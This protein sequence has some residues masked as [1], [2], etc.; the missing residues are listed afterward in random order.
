MGAVIVGGVMVVA[1]QNRNPKVPETVPASTTEVITQILS[2]KY[3]RSNESVVI[4]VVTDTGTFA[5][6]SVRF[7]N[8]PGG[9]M[10]FAAQGAAGWESRMTVTAS[11]PAPLQIR[12]ISR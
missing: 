12:S 9:G 1:S 6:G 3:K 11:C 2:D 8:V 10:W 4:E 5:H 7:K